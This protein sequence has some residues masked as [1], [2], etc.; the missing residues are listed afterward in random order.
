[1]A[2][3]QVTLDEKQVTLDEWLVERLREKLSKATVSASRTG[4][5]ILLYRNIMDE[6]EGSCR[7]R[8]RYS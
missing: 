7:R 4:K 3:K 2:N 6:N 5:P 8:S 1:M